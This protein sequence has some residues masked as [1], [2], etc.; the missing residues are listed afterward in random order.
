[1]ITVSKTLCDTDKVQDIPSGEMIE[2]LEVQRKQLDD[3][4][5]QLAVNH[6]IMELFYEEY[7]SMKRRQGTAHL[8][9]Y[10]RLREELLKDLRRI[11]KHRCS[12]KEIFSLF[13]MYINELSA[14][15]EDQGVEILRAYRG[16]KFDPETQKPI[17]KIET[18][19]KELEDTVRKVF[20]DGYRWN[21]MMLKKTDVAVVKSNKEEGN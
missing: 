19:K 5:D 3:V 14:I 18:D 12:Y 21:G 17:E 2:Q 4:I 20:G 11:R 13:G 1:M 16:T 8:M 7:Q 6:Q 9:N 10:I 15:L